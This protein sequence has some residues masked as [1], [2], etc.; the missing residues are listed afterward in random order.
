MRVQSAPPATETIGPESWRESTVRS[1][2]LAERLV[3]LS[4]GPDRA[5][6]ARS[7]GA[8]QPGTPPPRTAGSRE[9]GPGP[10]EEAAGSVDQQDVKKVRPVS[11]DTLGPVSPSP[12]LPPACL[13]ERCAGRSV[14]VALEHMRGVRAAEAALRGEAARLGAEARRLGRGRQALEGALS[15]LRRELLLNRRCVEGRGLRPT[16]AETVSVGSAGP[17]T[18]RRHIALRPAHG[19]TGILDCS[20]TVPQGSRTAVIQYHRDPGP[21]RYS[22]TGIQDCSHTVIY[23]TVIQSTVQCTAGL[24]SRMYYTS[25]HYSN[26]V[27]N[28]V[29]LAQRNSLR[30]SWALSSGTPPKRQSLL[31]TTPPSPAAR[32]RQLP[33]DAGLSGRRAS[34][35]RDGADQLLDRERAELTA[36]KAQLEGRLRAT[37]TQLQAL[38]VC[39]RRLLDCAAERSRVLD[40]IPHTGSDGAG[41]AATPS[42]CG[43][44]PTGPVTPECKEVMESSQAAF[45]QSQQLRQEIRQAIG[46]AVARQRATHQSV[47]E[48]LV[49]KI[50]ETVILSQR[51][52]LSSAATRQAV[53]QQQRQLDWIQHSRDSAL[54]PVS[55]ADLL[56]RERL[57][58]P[59]VRVYQRHPGTQLPEAGALI[60]VMQGSAGDAG[61]GVSAS[62]DGLV[63]CPGCVSVCVC[64]VM[65]WLAR[66]RFLSRPQGGAVLRRAL[67]SSARDLALLQLARLRLDEDLRGKRAAARV[68]SAVLRMRRR[69]AECPR[70]PPRLPPS[71]C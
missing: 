47:S 53:H 5:G 15:S 65:D 61:G 35:G 20:H 29:P 70:A 30:Y 19:R 42:P 32:E 68:D 48:G 8:A 62:C 49:R 69:H 28:I 1:I 17:R 27:W 25:L 23:N 56:T 36:L 18:H 37:V 31:E 21:Q 3:R 43:T 2:R 22:T 24:E 34:Q 9:A 16:G 59:V 26:V 33:Q 41:R 71:V 63:S 39:S 54:G 40:L 7:R 10:G 38:S 58:R 6:S 46:Q 67:G 14:G 66:C 60:Q 45:S 57:D 52:A 4:R 11:A 51:L 13:R 12:R 50:A 55:S 44:S 64:P